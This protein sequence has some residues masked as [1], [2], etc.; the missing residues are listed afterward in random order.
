[1]F[2]D[3]D[4]V[5]GTE[6]AA[7]PN[8]LPRS[9]KGESVLHDSGIKYSSPASLRK[10]AIASTIGNLIEIFDFIVYSFIAALVFGHLFFPGEEPWIGTLVAISTQGVAFV[11]RPVGAVLFGWV[12]D[13]FGRRVGLISTLGLM[14]FSTLALGLMPTYSTIGALAPILLISV[15]LIQGLAYG[16]EWG[17]AIL[18]AVEHAPP[19]KK[20]ILG[21]LPQ[22]GATLGVGLAAA[23]L[24]IISNAVGPEL[25]ASWGWRVPFLLG[26]VLII[27]GLFIRTR[28]EETPEF[29]H[30]LDNPS[31][32]NLRAG[33]GVTLREGWRPILAMILVWQAAAIAVLFFCTGLLAYVPRYVDGVTATDVQIGMVIATIAVVPVTVGSAYLGKRIGKEKVLLLA[34]ALSVGWA[35]PGYA[36]IT[37]GDPVLLWVAMTIGLINYGLTN[38][39]IG[40]TM[41]ENFPVRVRYLGVSLSFAVAS[42]I[43]GAVLPIPTLAWVAEL[44]G[45]SM[46]LALTFLGGGILTVAGA[47]WITRLP[48]YLSSTSD[49]AFDNDVPES[50]A[51]RG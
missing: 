19:E 11:A 26:A 42:I 45:S 20:T 5:P 49:G 29:Q 6:W 43:G 35:F 13:R 4:G 47:L 46:P 18:I 34:G 24:L 2:S 30:A 44:D 33:L 28:I 40:A 50:S 41:T 25:F 51:V 1:M 7:R 17:G 10:I 37:S 14:G 9:K 38:G 8:L 23:S 16:G 3:C 22:V 31:E 39:V 27:I 48:K 36:L 21:A 12:G 32:E 15:R